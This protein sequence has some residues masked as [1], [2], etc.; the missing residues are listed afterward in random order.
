MSKLLA[1]INNLKGLLFLF[2]LGIVFA[3]NTLAG[4]NLN[5]G[6]FFISY[7][8][9]IIKSEDKAKEELKISRTYNSK[10]VDIGWF[11]FGWGSDFETYLEVIPGGFLIHEY[12]AGSK[13]WF[14]KDNMQKKDIEYYVDKIIER[15]K[16]NNKNSTNGIP[17]NLKEKLINDAE[18]RYS[19]WKKYKANITLEN[20][21]V[22]FKPG[23]ELHNVQYENANKL[24]VTESG[25]TRYQNGIEQDKFDK[26][27]RLVRQHLG[28]D[29]YATL[30]YSGDGSR[31]EIHTNDGRK[32]L[33]HFKEF[34][35][36]KFVTKITSPAL[37][38]ESNYKYSG[39]NLIESIDAGGNDFKYKYDIN[40]NVIQVGYA[41]NTTLD[42]E[43]RE[44][45]YFVNKLT[46][47]DKSYRTFEYYN[48][49]DRPDFHYSTLTKL[50]DPKNLL[51]E[52]TFTEFYTEKNKAGNHQIRRLIKSTNS[53]GDANNELIDV[54]FNNCCGLPVKIRY[55]K[56]DLMVEYAQDPAIA[57]Q[58]KAI[59]SDKIEIK[60]DYNQAGK[61]VKVMDD[62]GATIAVEY[63]ESGNINKL[64]ES[65]DTDATRAKEIKEYFLK[66]YQIIK[67]VTGCECMR[68]I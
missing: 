25:Y 32:L 11:G 39:K 60:I 17:E 16:L 3:G 63:D 6:N 56:N 15:I 7:Y 54:S 21:P 5:N 38:K 52:L 51:S 45:D 49:P 53:I 40:H 24:I 59:K 67:L 31:I 22:K 35:N 13:N 34:D 62:D 50:Y 1:S 68:S 46:Y 26:N 48:Y 29:L 55:G 36:N 61:P 23:D 10:S 44:K 28:D 58:I 42:V 2:S 19:Y 9:F 12:G 30:S 43:Y 33:I 4:V 18:L 27:G 64:K 8:D 37:E 65:Q 47:R 20:E 14:Y 57:N 66:Y 41:D